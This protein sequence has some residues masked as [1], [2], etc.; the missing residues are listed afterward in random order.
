MWWEVRRGRC[1]VG[2]E[3]REVCGGGRGEGGV[4]W[5]VRRRRCEWCGGRM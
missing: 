4:W 5:G 2:G 3:E 1:V